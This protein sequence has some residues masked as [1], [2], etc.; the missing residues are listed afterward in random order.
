VQVEGIE[1]EQYQQV[2]DQLGVGLNRPRKYLRVSNA[3]QLA[4]RLCPTANP[5]DL[6]V[7]LIYHQFRNRYRRNDQS[8]KRVSGQALEHVIVSV[9]DQRLQSY[10]INLRTGTRAD[11]RALGL[12][13]QG[14]G[15]S[16]MDLI[17]EGSDDGNR[18][19]FGVLH[20]KASI[21]ER[22]RDD[23]PA[24][25][26]LIRQ[27]YWSSAV[28]M[29]D[30]MFP[31]PHGDGIVRGEFQGQGDKRAYIEVSGWF[32]G[33]YSFNLRTPESTGPTQS[34]SRI[35]AL[36]FSRPQPDVL[37][38]DIVQAWDNFRQRRH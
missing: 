34:G 13:E 8:W 10:R 18:T 14:H 28:T 5:A 12:E 3:M 19:V 25:A 20:I 17:L 4:L 1:P 29:D 16:T 9:Y 38:R 37:V 35:Y 7:H 21:A 24:S 15:L 32:S 30:K 23:A 2:S 36:S 6:W 11:A 22:F 33:C 27:G 31:P 26:Y